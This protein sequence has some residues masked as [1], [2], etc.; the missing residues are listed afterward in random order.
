MVNVG[1]CNI[2]Y[3]DAMGDFEGWNDLLQLSSGMI[4]IA[5]DGNPIIFW[6]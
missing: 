5:H 2:P 3:M 4:E 1:K 6:Y